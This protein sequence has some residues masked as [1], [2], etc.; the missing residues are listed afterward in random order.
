LSSKLSYHLIGRDFILLVVQRTTAHLKTNSGSDD[1]L[2]N[3]QHFE[4]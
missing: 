4:M 3:T 1:E 2:Q